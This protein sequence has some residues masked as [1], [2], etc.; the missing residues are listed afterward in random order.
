[1]VGFIFAVYSVAIIIC[2]PFVGTLI[3]KFGSDNLISFG[4][5]SMGV[6]F[7]L[8]ALIDGMSDQAIILVYS[9][10]LRLL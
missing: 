5:F 2:S 7:S 6:S 1:M 9:I 8:L 10:V 4:L 3:L